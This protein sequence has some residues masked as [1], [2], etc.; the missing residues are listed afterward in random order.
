M[1]ERRKWTPKE[2]YGFW[3]ARYFGGR[4]PNIRVGFSKV[5]CQGKDFHRLGATEFWFKGDRKYP[6]RILLNDRYKNEFGVWAA[7]LLHEMVHVQQW[8]T[9]TDQMHG[10]KFQ[11]RMKQLAAAGAFNRLW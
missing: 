3:N 9:P 7:T 11:K 5:L 6:V 4:L 8:R 2:L 10:R 1:T